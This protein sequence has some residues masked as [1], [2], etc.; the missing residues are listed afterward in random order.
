M[1]FDAVCGLQIHRGIAVLNSYF[2][3]WRSGN[4]MFWISP[5]ELLQ[6]FERTITNTY[7]KTDIEYICHSSKSGAAGCR[8]GYGWF[9]CGPRSYRV[10]RDNRKRFRQAGPCRAKRIELLEFNRD[11]GRDSFRGFGT[12]ARA[13]LVPEKRTAVLRQQ[14][15]R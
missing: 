2:R 5:L 10:K 1:G 7:H 8:G 12:A 13:P 15:I 9:T 14:V 11:R 4:V 3:W 6:R